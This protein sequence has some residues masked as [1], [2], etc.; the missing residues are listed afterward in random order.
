MKL[1]MF[2]RAENRMQIF[3]E[4][5]NLVILYHFLLF[6]DFV[7]DKTMK[8]EMG[9]SLILNIIVMVLANMAVIIL[10][11]IHDCKVGV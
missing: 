8:Y 9:F 11:F 2:V 6:T 7:P 5:Y 10:H 4:T 1:P 3:S